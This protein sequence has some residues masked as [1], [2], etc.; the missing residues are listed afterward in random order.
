MNSFKK[1]LARSTQKIKRTVASS[2][3]HKDAEY[4]MLMDSVKTQEKTLNQFDKHVLE[5]V[6]HL[7]AEMALTK[8]FAFDYKLIYTSGTAHDRAEDF[9]MV[10]ELQQIAEKHEK[11]VVKPFMEKCQVRVQQPIREY[12]QELSEATKGLSKQRHNRQ[13]DYEYQRD[14][15]NSI[16]SKTSSTPQQIEEARNLFEAAKLAFEEIDEEV[17]LHLREVAVKRYTVFHPLVADLFGEILSEYYEQLSSLSVL[18]RQL[19]MISPPEQIE[20][21]VVMQ[22]VESDYTH[23]EVISSSTRTTTTTTTLERQPSASKMFPPPPMQQVIPKHLDVQW[24]WLTDANEQKGPCSVNELK[25]LK[26]RGEVNGETYVCCEGMGNWQTVNEV[27]L[28]RYL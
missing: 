11:E 5:L 19:R 7:E 9:E 17:K 6:K 8:N 3:Q 28:A 15:Y 18:M 23:P 13:L 16:S 1:H 27:Y 14:K 26:L 22:K 4:D 20:M 21:T 24:Y 2:H 12:I 25:Q 10:K